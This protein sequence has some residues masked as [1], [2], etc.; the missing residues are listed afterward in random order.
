MII[1]AN[2]T[3][4]K[5]SEISIGIN[6]FLAPFNFNTKD[7]ELI[8]HTQKVDI[9][10]LFVK[11]AFVIDESKLVL[12]CRGRPKGVLEQCCSFLLCFTL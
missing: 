9:D 4:D 1:S 8:V 7:T 2:P 3:D 5:Q 11:T 12:F 6:N 10:H